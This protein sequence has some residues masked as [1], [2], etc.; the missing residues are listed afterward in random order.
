M[1]FLLKPGGV[2]SR[3][4][5]AEVALLGRAQFQRA[6]ICAERW[7]ASGGLAKVQANLAKVGQVRS[8]LGQIGPALAG[9]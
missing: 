8:T 7:P 1:S 2:K 5:G 6:Q 3:H 9:I 4:L